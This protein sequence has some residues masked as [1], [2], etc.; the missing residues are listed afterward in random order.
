MVTVYEAMKKIDETISVSTCEEIHITNSTGRVLAEQLF[1]PISLPPFRQS[2][3]DGYAL[4]FHPDY[5]HYLVIGII[6]AGSDATYSLEPGQCVR[7]FTGARVPDLANVVMMQEDCIIEDGFLILENAIKIGSHIRNEGEQIKSGTPVYQIGKKITPSCIGFLS[8]LGMTTIKVFKK[9]KITI[10]ATG[11]EL[12]KPGQPLTPGKIYESNSFMLQAAVEH[13][14][15]AQANIVWVK[16]DPEEL[17]LY[18]KNAIL[19]SDFVLISGGISA[20]DYD[21]VAETLT[22]NDVNCIFHK[23][24]QKP[25][26]PLY[27]G[28]HPDGKYVFGLPGNPAAA[29]TSFL[30]YVIP[31]LRKFCGEGYTGLQKINIPIE[32]SYSK[33]DGRGHFLKATIQNQKAKI[34]GG[35]NSDMMLSF[36]DSDALIYIPENVSQMEADEEVEIY[37]I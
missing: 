30:I 22:K 29:M 12:V 26:K 5:D 9:P 23:V 7:I 33:Q 20:G 34:L 28:K 4:N 16:D 6:A 8:S 13:Y 19:E 37:L 36:S 14:K 1:A 15:L 18:I 32:S 2:A 31:A 17:S 27:F 25:G 10:I 24:K 21:F 35:Q 3:M 11:S